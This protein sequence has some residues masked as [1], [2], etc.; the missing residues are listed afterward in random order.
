MSKNLGRQA[1]IDAAVDMV[2]KNLE[3]GKTFTPETLL[4]T[5]ALMAATDEI[6]KLE[7]AIPQIL[8]DLRDKSY[9]AGSRL[10]DI[11]I[12]ALHARVERKTVLSVPALIE[13]LEDADK[14]DEEDETDEAQ[15]GPAGKP[16]TRHSIALGE[17]I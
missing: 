6:E 2:K 9:A 12:A 7:K 5:K 14:T 13:M 4:L 3:E 16:A 11:T 10:S 15:L 17:F 8:M 1:V